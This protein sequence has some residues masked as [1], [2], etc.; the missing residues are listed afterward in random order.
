[1]GVIALCNAVIQSTISCSS[2]EIFAINSQNGIVEN[3]VFG[4]KILGEKNPQNHADI[5][6]PMG[7]LQVGKFGAIPPTDADDIS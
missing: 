7:T 2:L 5:L 1:M 3:Y 6:S 4:P